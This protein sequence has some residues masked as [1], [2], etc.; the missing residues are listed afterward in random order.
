MK[1]FFFKHIDNSALIVFRIIFGLLCVFESFGAILT[2][3]VKRTLIDP[4]FTFTVIGFEWVQ[5]L[6]GNWMYLYY[7]V[8]GI[9]GFLIMIGYKYRI[10]TFFFALMWTVTYIMQKCSYNNHY[11]LMVLLSTIM[12]FLPANKLYSVDARQNPEIK[13]NSM[14]Q[15]VS[16]VMIFQMFIVYTFGA[17]AKLYPDWLDTTFIE[18]LMKSKQHYHLIGNLLQE[19]A[20]H[21]FLTYGGILFDGLV[22]PFLLFKPTRKLA[23]AASIFFHLFNSIVFQ[24]GVFPYL[25][26]GFTLFFFEPKTIQKIFLKK[27]TFYGINEVIVPS[28]HKPLIAIFCVYFIIQIALP[29]RHW[30]IEDNVLWTEEGHRLAWRM[31]LRTKSGR[32]KFRVIDK[33]TNQRIPIKL[34]NYL[35]KKQKSVISNKP[36]LIWQMAQRLKHIYSENGQEVLVFVDCY[37]SVNGRPLSRLIDPEVDLANT[38]WDYFKHSDWILPSNLD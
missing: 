6:P 2:G 28:Y 3:W 5:P 38:K 37:T 34:S 8:M 14:P 18:L 11:Y 15:W 32:I 25:S 19:K 22:I 4:E 16:Y 23:F 27:K 10:S 29:V 35:S 20:V 21:Y 17:I 36:D 24:I 13:S 7:F 12:I 31:M 33:Q 26:L 9:F 1:Q 30:F